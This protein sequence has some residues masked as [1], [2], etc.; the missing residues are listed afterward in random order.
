MRPHGYEVGGVGYLV[1]EGSERGARARAH[2]RLLL[3]FEPEFF[4]F[5]LSFVG[6]LS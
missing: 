6:I 1:G 5:D 2:G 3:V 4:V